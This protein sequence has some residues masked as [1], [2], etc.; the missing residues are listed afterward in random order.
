MWRKTPTRVPRG[1]RAPRQA[2]E[3]QPKV[4][5]RS[6][7]EAVVKG[8]VQFPESSSCTACCAHM[9]PQLYTFIQ[10]SCRMRLLRESNKPAAGVSAPC[11]LNQTQQSIIDMY[12]A[13]TPRTTWLLSFK[14]L[15]PTSPHRHPTL[16][17]P[18]APRST[19][20]YH[21]RP[22][23]PSRAC[24][25]S[26]PSQTCPAV[27]NQTRL[28]QHNRELEPCP[29]RTRRGLHPKSITTPPL[30]PPLRPL[31]PLINMSTQL[32]CCER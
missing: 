20:P 9:M 31:E 8:N 16:Q 30:R 4:L 12:P 22:R 2:N 11:R 17:L 13:L 7:D 6:C 26:C 10:F 32:Y 3:F 1:E 15:R 23:N 27:T 24:T 5:V 25:C 18:S 14:L 29:P 21:F 28:H 19:T